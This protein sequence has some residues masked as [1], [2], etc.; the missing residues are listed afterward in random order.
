MVD[1]YRQITPTNPAPI[2]Q[3]VEDGE[4][5]DSCTNDAYITPL[6]MNAAVWQS[7]IHGA[8]GIIYFDYTFC[9]SEAGTDN[10]VLDTYFQ[11]ALPGRTISIYDQIKTTD[12]QVHALAPVINAPFAV[13]YVTVNPAGYDFPNLPVTPAFTFAA[14]DLASTPMIDVMAKWYRGRGARERRHVFA[15]PRTSEKATRHL[16]HFH[17]RRLECVERHGPERGPHHPRRRRKLHGH[18]RH[19]A[20]GAHLPD[21][22]T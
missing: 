13:D 11:T 21:P 9:G 19:R 12:A 14:G 22:L 5:G 16:S 7:I 17:G 18:V 8:R 2:Y 10:D 6:E 20:I 1:M 4:P 15:S 3:F